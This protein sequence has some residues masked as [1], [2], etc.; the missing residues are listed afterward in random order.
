MQNLD[1]L[2]EE[3]VTNKSLMKY[4]KLTQR[5]LGGDLV[6]DFIDEINGAGMS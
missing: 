6:D 3:L 1:K 5:D 4:A 2:I